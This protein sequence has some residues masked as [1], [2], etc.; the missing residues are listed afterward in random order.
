MQITIPH[1]FTKPQALVRVKQALVQARPQLAGKAT[2]EEERWDEDTLTFAFVAEGQ[3]I[4][5]TF[6]V[7]DSEFE[8]NAKLPLMLRLF[9]GKIKR[10]IEEQTKQVL[11]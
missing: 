11:G 8:L 2:I 9:E 5:G 10:A 3:R 6:E 7:R 4:S 1:K